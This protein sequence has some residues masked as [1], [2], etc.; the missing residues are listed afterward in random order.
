MTADSEHLGFRRQRRSEAD[1]VH[2][3]K[4]VLSTHNR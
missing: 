3:L 4:C 2:I 1:P